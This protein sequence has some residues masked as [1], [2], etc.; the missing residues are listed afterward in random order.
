MGK[1]KIRCINDKNGCQEIL[2]LDNLDNHEKQCP[3]DLCGNCFC[4][5]S[6]NH[7]CIKTLLESKQ[8][9]IQSNE[10]LHK[11]LKSAKDTITTLQSEIKNYLQT[12]QELS[13]SNPLQ[14]LPNI[15]KE[16]NFIFHL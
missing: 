4:K 7:D 5:K 8:R 2:L 15:T 13:N 14:K 11:E 6:G 3:Y 9:L 12:I 1:L 16:V 10:E